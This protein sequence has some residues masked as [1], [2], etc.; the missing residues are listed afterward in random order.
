MRINETPS[1]HLPVSRLMDGTGLYLPSH[2][3][4]SVKHQANQIVLP[5][6]D[7]SAANGKGLSYP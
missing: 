4:T 1:V 6:L 7:P 3:L 5:P 2:W